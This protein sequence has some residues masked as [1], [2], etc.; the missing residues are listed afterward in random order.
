[1]FVS[2]WVL[3][4]LGSAWEGPAAHTL[5][6]LASFSRLILFDKRGT[7]LSDRMTVIPDLETRMD[8]IGAVMDAVGSK[9]A[10]I[11]GVS[12]GGPMTILF[13]ASYPERT[14]PPSCTARSARSPWPP[15]PTSRCEASDRV[16]RPEP[17]IDVQSEA[18]DAAGSVAGP[19]MVDW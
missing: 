12:E 15:S 19:V 18:A 9:R 3:S 10:A 16:P 11:M 2:G 13:A 7:G 17:V 5:S 6:R 4:V 1:V 8:D 14:R